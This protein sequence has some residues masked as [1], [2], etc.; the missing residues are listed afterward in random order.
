MPNSFF[1]RA[2]VPCLA[3]ILALALGTARTARAEC[4]PSGRCCDDTAC[5]SDGR[6]NDGD[7]LVDCEDPDC[8]GIDPC[9]SSGETDC[10]NG[11]D[12]DGDGLVDCEDP[13]CAT[14]PPC[15]TPPTE[16][17]CTNG[18]DDDG[19]GAADCDDE[20]CAEDPAC[21]TETDCANGEDD[22]GD[23]LVDCE[24]TA[25]CSLDPACIESDCGNGEDDDGD[26]L[27]DCEDVDCA[28][29]GCCPGPERCDDLVDN[30]VDGLIDCEDVDSC[31][32][33]DVCAPPDEDCSNGED[34]DG[35]GLTDCEDPECVRFVDC[36]PVETG[37]EP[38]A[39]TGSLE[40]VACLWPA[41]HWWACF[42][43]A[44]LGVEAS[45]DC[46]PVTV[47]LTR[48]ESSQPE[49]ATGDGATAPD[50][51]L[52]EDGRICVRAE[53]D[54]ADPA[55]RSYTIYA[56]AVDAVGRISEEVPVGVI[57][58]PHEGPGAGCLSPIDIG[59][60]LLHP[61]VPRPEPPGGGPGAGGDE[62]GGRRR[63]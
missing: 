30:D 12:D 63:R 32:D 61:R 44:D 59:M 4:D 41:N 31:I 10:A 56:M 13:D 2:L 22:D 49:D 47:L 7:G 53:R 50:C 34:D 51:E 1:P 62:D 20:D 8:A 19:D 14:A 57:L 40:V 11:E 3:V 33:A 54:G 52:Q 39:I 38:P 45:G 21:A 17:D 26:G 23:G 27:T 18:E 28:G 58:V 37:A 60:R 46:G 25:D 48:C 36:P 42:D 9:G 35:D 16:T 43:L 24:D 6:D 15:T 55:G 5:C 29:V